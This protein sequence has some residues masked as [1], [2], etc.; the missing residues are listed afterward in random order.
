[1]LKTEYL[2]ELAYA[3]YRVNNGY[4]KETQRFSESKPTIWSNRELVL[5]SASHYFPKEMDTSNEWLPSDFVPL[6]ITDEDRA[7][8]VDAHKHFRRYSFLILGDSLTQFQKDYFTVSCLEMGGR[9]D[10]GRLAYVPAFVNREI[11]DIAYKR[12]LKDEF[13][14][15]EHIQAKEV[16]GELEILKRIW[17]KDYATYMYFGNLCGNLVSFS[18]A[19]MYNVGAMYMLRGR[20]RSHDRERET[21]LPM[22]KLN[23]VKLSLIEE[24]A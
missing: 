9:K 8:V 16:A 10:V 11:H 14:D 19:D 23:Y 1:M 18:K 7:G 4:V 17:I 6:V 20:V 3:A 24:T 12:R 22:T 15:S 5:F 13:T 2:L 21:D